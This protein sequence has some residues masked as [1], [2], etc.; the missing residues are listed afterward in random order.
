MLA[1]GVKGL[2]GTVRM[3]VRNDLV[4][5]LPYGTPLISSQET[6]AVSTPVLPEQ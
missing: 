2:T 3:R 5:S 1:Q 4:A 6:S